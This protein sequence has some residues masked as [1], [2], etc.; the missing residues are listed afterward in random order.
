MSDFFK[1]PDI[2]LIINVAAITPNASEGRSLSSQIWTTAKTWLIVLPFFAFAFMF[3]VLPALSIAVGS[4]QDNDTG[5]FTIANIL[6]LRRPSILSAYSVSIRISLITALMGGVFGFL[7]AYSITLGNLPSWIRSALL[8]FSGVASNFAGV[9]LAFAFVATFGRLG[10]VT[11]LL[12]I[13]GIDLYDAGFSLYTFVGLCITYLY[14]QLPLMILVITPS[15]D[16]MKKQ[17]REACE[18]LGGSAWHFWRHIAFP[19]LVPPLLGA[20]VL[21]FGNAFGAYATAYALTSGQINLVT[22]V[23]GQQIS[24]D[25]LH[26]PAL[27]NALA[28]GMVIVM[29]TSV[30]IYTLLMRR[31]AKWLR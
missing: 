21:L 10:V 20:M 30:A 6:E 8:T 31:S 19:I 28:L 24:G 17:W 3:L 5:A 18:S 15:L 25:A 14:F 4:F 11:V 2:F 13:V 9:P 23:I 1:K 29:V 16:G 27:G 12:K 22:M 26:N 7:M